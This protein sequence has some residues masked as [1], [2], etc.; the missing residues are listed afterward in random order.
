MKIVA[1]HLIAAFLSCLSC[2]IAP[3]ALAAASE[4]QSFQSDPAIEKM[5]E[6]YAQD[7]VDIAA[8][9]F[10]IQLDWSDASIANI[11]KA[12][13]QMNL[14]YTNTNPK[15][16]DEQVMSFAKGFGSYVGEV[17]RRNHGG[18]RGIATLGESRFPALRSDSGTIFW[19]WARAFKRITEGAQDNVSDYYSALLKN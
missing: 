1:K 7:T 8:K 11:E 13:A 14:S 17:Y 12:L 3:A 6:A 10:A 16:T 19:P 2:L 15:P 18:E 9:H 4:G 5:A